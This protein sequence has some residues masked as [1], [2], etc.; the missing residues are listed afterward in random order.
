[1]KGIEEARKFVHYLN[2]N[3]SFAVSLLTISISSQLLE[4]FYKMF[5]QLCNNESNLVTGL[6]VTVS[7]VLWLSKLLTPLIQASR[8]SS[9]CN[10]LRYIG[11]ELRARPFGYQDT[12]QQDLDSIVT[13]TC[14]LRL[15]GKIV[16]CP[17]KKSFLFGVLAIT[18][19]I[20]LFL[21]QINYF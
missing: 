7:T 11:L 8:L 4:A 6:L 10:E 21:G 5:Y 19:I 13:Y 17:I 16:Y 9:T 14:N 12:L 1:M 20:I 3:Q 15:K 18:I 2:N